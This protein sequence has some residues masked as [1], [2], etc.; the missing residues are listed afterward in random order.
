MFCLSSKKVPKRIFRPGG[1]DVPFFQSNDLSANGIRA[2]QLEACGAI[3][4]N[5]EKNECKRAKLIGWLLNG[6]EK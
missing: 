2:I 6:W 1:G 3:C 5:P 4:V